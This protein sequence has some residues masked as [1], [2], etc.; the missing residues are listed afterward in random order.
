[1]VLLLA[2][3]TSL[4]QSQTT[5]VVDRDREV[6][7]PNNWKRVP[8]FWGKRFE[9]NEDLYREYNN[10]ITSVVEKGYARTV[11]IADDELIEMNSK[12]WYMSHHRDHHPQKETLH[13]VFDCAA[14]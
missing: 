2:G 7:I 12:V 1:M 11:I 10:F 5:R 4:S 8:L 9:K 13:V 3:T 14:R 6:E